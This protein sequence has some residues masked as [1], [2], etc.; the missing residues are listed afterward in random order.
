MGGVTK[1]LDQTPVA[2]VAGTVGALG[3]S[4]FQERIHIV[5]HEQAAPLLQA[6]D[7]LVDALLERRGEGGRWRLREERDAIGDQLL[8]GAGVSYRAPP[9]RPEGVSQTA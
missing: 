4:F 6:S 2:L 3:V 5:Q 8:S 9:P 7:Q 1:P